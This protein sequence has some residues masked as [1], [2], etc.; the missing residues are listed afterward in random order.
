MKRQIGLDFGTTTTVVMYRD[1]DEKNPG[2]EIPLEFDSSSYVP[3]LILQEG[4]IT[5]KTGKTRHTDEKFGKEAAGAENFHSLLKSNFK[6]DLISNDFSARKEAQELTQ[7]F[8]RYLYAQYS[9]AAL[10][11]KDS[12][13]TEVTTWVTHPAKFPK[14][15]QDFL[16]NAAEK[17]G[18]PNVKLLDESKAAMTFA[19]TYETG[20]IKKYVDSLGKDKIRVLLIDM[21]AGTTDIAVFSHNIVDPTEFEPICSWPEK[22]NH[23]FGGREI[24]DILCKFYR[25]EL[26]EENIVSTLTKNNDPVLGGRILSRVVK[27]YKESSLSSNLAA[28]KSIPCPGDLEEIVDEMDEE[29]DVQMD[30]GRFESLLKDYLPQFPVLVK[31]ALAKANMTG[32]D[33]DMVI[34]TGGHSQWYFVPDMLTES[35]I[36]NNA[37]FGFRE[38]HTAVA[39]GAAW[40]VQPKKPVVQ[41]TG[42]G[43][44]QSQNRKEVTTVPGEKKRD[45]NKSGTSQTATS[46]SVNSSSANSIQVK[47]NTA[48]GNELATL[49]VNPAN[50]EMPVTIALVNRPYSLRLHP[51]GVEQCSVNS[52]YQIV[53]NQGNDKRLLAFPTRQDA[54]VWFSKLKALVPVSNKPRY[55]WD[56]PS[57]LM[58]YTFGCV[59]HSD[60]YTVKIVFNKPLPYN[61]RILFY[62]ADGKLLS[63]RYSH[64]QSSASIVTIAQPPFITIPSDLKVGSI[65]L[66]LPVSPSVYPSDHWQFRCVSNPYSHHFKIERSLANPTIILERKPRLLAPARSFYAKIDGQLWKISGGSR[67]AISVTP[68]RHHVVGGNM[69][70]FGNEPIDKEFGDS[71]FMLNSGETLVYGF[72]DGNQKI[73]PKILDD[74]SS[75]TYLEIK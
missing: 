23:N 10:E 60:N 45:Q 35:G 69:S 47:L 22:G 1:Y 7:K 26:G 59:I 37:I 40:Y 49:S 68:D 33:V 53:L 12:P 58:Q 8:F 5:T 73:L 20:Q 52:T 75:P 34:L 14:D 6:M 2:K 48:Y 41:P 38:P 43:T 9:A 67:K 16:K 25:K 42:K 39:R 56:I 54:D 27:D 51:D 3:T 63:D 74:T 28:R 24:D 17:A 64:V 70:L 65:V 46:A 66:A 13:I 72:E 62:D 36:S 11:R 55:T 30:R 18:F 61:N 15:A 19:L 4:N 50:K 31:G 21:G 29:P 57:T 71:Y 32:R 44:T